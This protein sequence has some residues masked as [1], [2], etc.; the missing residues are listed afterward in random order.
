MKLQ[1]QQLFAGI[2]NKMGIDDAVIQV[3]VPENP[4]HGDYTTNV[5]MLLAGRLKSPPMKIAQEI[6]DQITKDHITSPNKWLDKM[7]SVPPGF[8]NIF[9]SE[10]CLGAEVSE[11]LRKKDRYGMD[12]K[13]I[14]TRLSV[15][16]TSKKNIQVKGSIES[17]EKMW[18]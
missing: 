13:V 1:M 12:E 4:A 3:S 11:V 7:E 2:V 6:V 9:V 8:I 17:K 10:D 16:R 18:I 5:A 15:I 14:S